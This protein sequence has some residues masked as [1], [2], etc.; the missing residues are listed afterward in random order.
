MFLLITFR[1][2]GLR[3]LFLGDVVGEPGRKVLKSALPRLKTARSIDLVIANAEN[4]AGGSGINP[5]C[6]SQLVA[7]GVHAFTMGDHVFKKREIYPLFEQGLP[8]CR[9][10]NF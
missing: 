5:R 6:F 4:A 9:P 7:A 8:L 1:G 10:A 3:I 2:F